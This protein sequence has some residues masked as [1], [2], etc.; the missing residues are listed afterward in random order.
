VQKR[1]KKRVNVF[2]DGEYAFSLSMD[3][4][5]K[6]HKGQTL[7]AAEMTILRD[8]D[9]VVKAVDSAARFLSYR[10]RSEQEVRRNLEE[11]ET[12]PAVVEIALERLRAQGFLD[13]RKFAA[14]WIQQRNLS[15]PV[16]PKAL[17]YEL[18]QKGISNTLIEEVLGEV[19]SDDAA[20]RAA[21]SQMR[22][23]RGTDPKTFRQKLN[24]FLQ[25]RGFTY[26]DARAA[27]ARLIEDID[28]DDPDFFANPEGAAQDDDWAEE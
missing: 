14:F 13:D 23:L 5:A 20:Y 27:I 25:R 22:K 9:A 24:G 15:K 3:E 6:L 19:D 17:R 12:A 16:S 8:E 21:Q 2:I 7:T 1:N 28:A 10:P 26:S 11:K 18:R 4:A